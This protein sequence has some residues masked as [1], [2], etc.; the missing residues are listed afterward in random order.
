VYQGSAEDLDYMRETP[1]RRA[2]NA[3]MSQFDE[4]ALVAGYGSEDLRLMA[5]WVTVLPTSS[6]VPVN[7]NTAAPELLAALFSEGHEDLAATVMAARPWSS[8]A[9][10]MQKLDAGEAVLSPNLVGVSSNFFALVA[11]LEVGG[12]RIL[13]QSRFVRDQGGAVR[14]YQRSIATLPPMLTQDM[15]P[16][17]DEC[18]RQTQARSGT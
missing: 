11:A 1:S 6:S 10:L 9:E 3:P 2:A 4:L 16:L 14:T 12:F 7:V 13:Y 8:V 5:P 17:P 15:D 18:R